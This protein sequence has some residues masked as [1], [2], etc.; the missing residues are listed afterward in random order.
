MVAQRRLKIVRQSTEERPVGGSI[1]VAFATTDMKHVDQHF[2]SAQSF[3]IYEVAADEWRMVEVSQFDPQAQDGN[4]AK[5]PAKIATLEGCV[6]V[7]CQ[8]VGHSAIQQLLALGIQPLKVS[9]GSP[10][11]ELL[12]DLQDEIRHGPSTWLARALKRGDGDEA[13]FDSME[14]EGWE[15]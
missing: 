2:G 1:R 6:A 7:Y 9:E 13:R 11:G 5:L 15:E 12:S 8:A 10:I 3:A 4:E 14:E